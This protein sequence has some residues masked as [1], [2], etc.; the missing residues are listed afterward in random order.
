MQEFENVKQ[1]LR[2]AFDLVDAKGITTDGAVATTEQVQELI[3]E[4]LVNLADLL[5]MEELYL[6]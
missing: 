4:N 3:K 2:A 1:A 5:G 6:D